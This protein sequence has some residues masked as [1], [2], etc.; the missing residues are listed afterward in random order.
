MFEIP[1]WAIVTL[2]SLLMAPGVILVFFP[3]FPASLY[4]LVMSVIF[5][6]VDCFQHLTVGNL[7]VLVGIFILGI[8]IDMFSGVLTAKYFG[9]SG[10]SALIGLAGFTVGMLVFPPIGGVI[11]L[12]LAVL[13]SEIVSGKSHQRSIMIA[14][15]SVLGFFA[16]AILSFIVALAFFISF[17]LMAIF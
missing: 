2:F 7:L 17:V 4:L 9:A 3:V 16:G 12:F 8:I 11:G 5:G 1:Y 6:F 15:G 14:G 10:R 13:A